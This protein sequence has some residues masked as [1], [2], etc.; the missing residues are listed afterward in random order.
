MDV[1]AK[2]L[3]SFATI[4]MWAQYLVVRFKQ[5][6]FSNVLS[7]SHYSQVVAF[8]KVNPQSVIITLGIILSG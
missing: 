3:I 5:I 1:S 6:A 2:S 4:A 7:M 8:F